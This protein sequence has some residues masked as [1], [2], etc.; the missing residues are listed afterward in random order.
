VVRLVAA[1]HL[2]QEPLDRIVRDGRGRRCRTDHE[3]GAEDCDEFLHGMSPL[4]DSLAG[5][6]GGTAGYG[7]YSQK[8]EIFFNCIDRFFVHAASPPLHAQRR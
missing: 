6:K 2:L 3:E 1:R 7:V 8:N 5:C 4:N